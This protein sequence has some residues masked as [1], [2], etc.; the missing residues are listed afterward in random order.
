[1]RVATNLIR[2]CRGYGLHGLALCIVPKLRAVERDLALG[3]SL[4]TRELLYRVNFA[5]CP[6]AHL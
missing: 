2:L 3:Y 1:M 4:P 5:M 6:D